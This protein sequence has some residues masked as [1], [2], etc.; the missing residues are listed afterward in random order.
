MG[1]KHHSSVLDAYFDANARNRRSSSS[2]FRT[3]AYEPL[4]RRQL[5][6]A[7]VS[8]EIMYAPDVMEKG[9]KSD[10]WVRVKI[11]NPESSGP[12]QVEELGLYDEDPYDADTIVHVTNP[13]VIDTAGTWFDHTFTDVDLTAFDDD[14]DGI[15]LYAWADVD[16]DTTVWP[17]PD[18]R[19]ATQI[20]QLQRSWTILAY[21]A[22]DNNLADTCRYDFNRFASVGSSAD[23]SVVAM[24]DTLGPN[25]TRWGLIH[26]GDS[27][28]DAN[29]GESGEKN[30]GTEQTLRDFIAWTK[31]NHP[32]DHYAIILGDHGGGSTMGACWDDTSALA[33]LTLGDLENAL[34]GRDMEMIAFDACLMGMAE[35]AI[36]LKDCA[37]FLVASESVVGAAGKHDDFLTALINDPGMNA[38]QVA[39]A[40]YENAV[41]ARPTVSMVDLSKAAALE[42]ALGDLAS[43]MLD[44]ATPQ[45]W[46]VAVKECRAA[47]YFPNDNWDYRDI[48]DWMDGI[49]GNS[50]ATA[51]MIAKAQAVKDEVT[52]AVKHSHAKGMVGYGLSIYAPFANLD[53][54]YTLDIN[55]V[56]NTRW[57]DFVGPLGASIVTVIDTSGSMSGSSLTSAKNASKQFVD[58]MEVEDQIGVVRYSSS[59]STA[60]NLTQIT[61]PAEKNAA[62]V[63][64]DGLSASGSTSIGSGV[65]QAYSELDNADKTGALAMVVMSDGLQNTDPEPISVINANKDKDVVIYTVGFGSNADAALLSRMASMTGGA[66]YSAT[67]ANIQQIYDKIKNSMTNWASTNPATQ[68][69]IPSE[70]AVHSISVERLTQEISFTIDWAGSDLDLSLIAPD[71]TVIDR[72]TAASDP[73][74]EFTIGDTYEFVNIKLP[75][76]GTWQMVATAVDVPEEG[77]PVN[78]YASYDSKLVMNFSTDKSYYSTGEIV[79]IEAGLHDFFGIPG[80]TVEATIQLPTGYGVDKET[81]TL[82][83]DGQHG[84]GEAGD[85]VY[86]NDYK[87]L[88]YPGT[89]NVEVNAEGVSYMGDAFVRY[90]FASIV[91]EG[92]VVS[93]LPDSIDGPT[94]GVRCQP[95][96]YQIDTFDPGMYGY[97]NIHVDWGDGSEAEALAMIDPQSG[98]HVAFGHRYG[99]PG[100]YEIKIFPDNDPGDVIVQKSVDVGIAVTGNDPNHPG[101]TAL[102]VG[103]TQGHDRIY[104]KEYPNGNVRVRMNNPF[105]REVFRP[106]EDGQIYVFTCDGNDWVKL[107]HRV[108]HDAEI[109]SGPGMDFVMGAAGDDLLDGGA[110][111]D[112]LFGMAGDDTLIGGPGTDFLFGQQGNDTLHGGEGRDF[113][114][115]LGGDDLL[116]GGPGD[117][118]LFG[119]GGNDVLVG[120]GQND[121]LHGGMGRDVLIGGAERD[122]LFGDLGDDLLIGGP[123]IHDADAAALR[124]ILSEWTTLLPTAPRIQSLKTQALAALVLE[125]TVLDDGE[126]DTLFGGPGN[127]WFLKFD[128]DFLPWIDPNDRIN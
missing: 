106:S 55:L 62:K 81:V 83:D 6:A 127:D 117:D 79:H 54:G 36:E 32:S 2:R 112:H 39:Y 35:V 43:Y 51:T 111:Q 88:F 94:A 33:H 50:D 105:Y 30:T 21:F 128:Q 110:G 72:T 29:W 49:I 37:Q 121:R 96:V 27:A 57:A 59:A 125:T 3:L 15:E 13:L 68:R 60:Y 84:D 11:D 114:Y 19:S 71:G 45:E 52:D 48:V 75:A 101:E 53:A 118:F 90:D 92:E 78:L 74:V 104:I 24:L 8:V 34:Q 107:Y 46:V 38:E 63:A 31:T 126:Q 119:Y 1:T 18:G 109:Y 99:A 7:T 25:D 47:Q 17:D 120:G 124:T 26:S 77:E 103:G 66:Y 69:I 85:G 116:F 9:E 113:L 87:G 76:A 12:W 102:F 93:Q 61:G 10:V 14:A 98:D 95:L 22:G 58:K 89:Y 67:G 115:G 28:T 20:V 70:M 122:L 82:H 4:E 123:T 64:I 80:A 100:V 91:A 56:M 42:T 108:G 65:Q 5:L 97:Q 40:Y 16:D 41:A 44:T 23:V 73:N 86:A